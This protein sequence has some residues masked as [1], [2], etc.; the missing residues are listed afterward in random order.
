MALLP[1]QADAR[2]I[3]SKAADLLIVCDGFKCGQLSWLDVVETRRL[4]RE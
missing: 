3:S 1:R 2:S 4:K